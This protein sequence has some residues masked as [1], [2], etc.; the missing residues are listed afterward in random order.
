[1]KTYY[2]S[3]KKWLRGQANKS[4]LL[5]DLGERCCLGFVGQQCG[6]ADEFLLDRLAPRADDFSDWPEWMMEDGHDRSG[7]CV[8]AMRLNDNPTLSNHERESKLRALFRKHGDRI[9]FKP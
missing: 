5:N 2:V 9:V 1:M 7:A 4:V 8:D 3:R 6:M